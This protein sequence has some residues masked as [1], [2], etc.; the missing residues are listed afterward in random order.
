MA[1]AK[2]KAIRGASVRKIPDK[3]EIFTHLLPRANPMG[4]HPSQ[5]NEIKIRPLALFLFHG[6]PG[7]IR[8]HDPLFRRQVL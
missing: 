8:T 7:G 3:S 6:T 1:F 5:Y 2:A 4:S